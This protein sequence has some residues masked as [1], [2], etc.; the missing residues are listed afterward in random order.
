MT[1]QIIELANRPKGAPLENTFRIREIE[2]PQPEDGEVL[3]KSKF[4]SVDPYMRGRM[5]E[6]KSYMPPFEEAKLFPVGL[7][8]K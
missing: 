3:L 7:S 1:N 6:E 8:Q 5:R 2:M 4:I